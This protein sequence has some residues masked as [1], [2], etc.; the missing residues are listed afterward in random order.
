MLEG[1]S[2]E[3][4]PMTTFSTGTGEVFYL[5]TWYFYVPSC[6]CLLTSKAFSPAYFS[7]DKKHIGDDYFLN[8]GDKVRYFFEEEAFDKQGNLTVPKSKAINKI[9]HGMCLSGLVLRSNIPA[10]F[11]FFYPSLDTF[12]DTMCHVL[13]GLEMITYFS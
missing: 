8:S 5:F 9:G 13:W 7:Q 1:F 3:G 12:F 11:F 4:H 6:L 10:P 2:L